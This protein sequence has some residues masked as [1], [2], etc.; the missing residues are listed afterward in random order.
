MIDWLNNPAEWPLWFFVSLLIALGL[1]VCIAWAQW[2]N[3]FFTELFRDII[4]LSWRRSARKL[5]ITDVAKWVRGRG[6]SEANAIAIERSNNSHP[7]T[8]ED[9][10]NLHLTVD[11]RPVIVIRYDY[12]IAIA[13]EFKEAAP[14]T[15]F[16][17]SILVTVKNTIDTY[18]FSNTRLSE[19]IEIL[20]KMIRDRDKEIARLK[21]PKVVL[22]NEEQSIDERW[23]GIAGEIHASKADED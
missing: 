3:S 5:S 2:E 8:G 9:Q 22:I 4:P 15:P 14:L 21:A 23:H 19:D 17:T 13:P 18:H 16:W 11:G 7:N 10:E 1:L 6:R 20:E 12:E